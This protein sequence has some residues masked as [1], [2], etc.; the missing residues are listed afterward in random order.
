MIVTTV[1]IVVLADRM[2]FAESGV[3]LLAT[4]LL[5]S[6]LSTRNRR[7]L[8][9]I[10]KWLA[11]YVPAMIVSVSMVTIDLIENAHCL[12][13]AALAW[14]T[15]SDLRA[16]LAALI[17]KS[18][19]MNGLGAWLNS[20][21]LLGTGLIPIAL[22]GYALWVIG[23]PT[24]IACALFIA[25]SVAQVEGMTRASAGRLLCSVRRMNRE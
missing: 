9:T 11:S 16:L 7:W 15:M 10:R 12:W 14:L 23:I 24:E 18:T 3:Y 13:I 1:M 21:Q 4:P 20:L 2:G 17:L 22:A 6:L 5:A 25:G 8:S 19:G